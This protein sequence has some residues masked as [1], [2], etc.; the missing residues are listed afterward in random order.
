MT[1]FTGNEVAQAKMA[2]Q[3]AIAWHRNQPESD[4]GN[5]E[6][7]KLTALIA[8]FGGVLDWAYPA[9]YEDLLDGEEDI[10]R[11][12]VDKFGVVEGRTEFLLA[13]DTPTCRKDA[14]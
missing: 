9:N 13:A 11:T 5:R 1:T 7:E 8:K 3:L 2:A 12:C 6:I 10:L 4:F 14:R